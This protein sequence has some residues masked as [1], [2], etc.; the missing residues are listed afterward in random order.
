MFARNNKDFR[1][2]GSH[3]KYFGSLLLDRVSEL[4]IQQILKASCD[5]ARRELEIRRAMNDGQ[6]QIEEVRVSLKLLGEGKSVAARSIPV[7]F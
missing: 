4:I 7:G 2:L 6:K 3:F 5:A 1:S